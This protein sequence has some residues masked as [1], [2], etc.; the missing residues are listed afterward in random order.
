MRVRTA[1]PIKN[2]TAE[3]W[4]GGRNNL[5][6]VTGNYDMKIIN[7]KPWDTMGIFY[8]ELRCKSYCLI[9]ILQYAL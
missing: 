2:K 9:M 3:Y 5:L 4:G 1:H 6:L 7:I 8:V